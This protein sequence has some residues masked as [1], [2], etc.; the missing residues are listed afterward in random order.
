MLKP[1]EITEKISF[2]KE[3]LID[4]IKISNIN[5]DDLTLSLSSLTS[6][7]VSTQKRI[8]QL[9]Y[10]HP[11]LNLCHEREISLYCYYII[12]R[13]PIIAINEN[14]VHYRDVNERFSV[15]LLLSSIVGSNSKFIKYISNEYVEFLV[16]MFFDGD[17]TMDTIWLLTRTWIQIE[18]KNR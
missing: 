9:R 8:E 10:T 14:D 1:D 18:Q 6:V 7:I 13:K 15:Y 2:F 4:F 5:E 16:G 3:I 12:K 17:I 11:N